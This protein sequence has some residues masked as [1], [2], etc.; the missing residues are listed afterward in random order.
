MKG[1]D[2]FILVYFVLM[3]L[4]FCGANLLMSGSEKKLEKNYLIEISRMIHEH[5]ETGEFH[6]EN[7]ESILDIIP[8]TDENWY[9]TDSNYAVRE[10]GGK[11]YRIDYI[12]YESDGNSRKIMNAVIIAVS[13]SGLI[14]LIWIRRTV[15]KPFNTIYTLPYSLAKGNLTVP[16]QENKN[17]YFGKFLWGLDM[18][19][20]KLE[21]SKQQKLEQAKAEKLMLLSLSHDIKTP[22]SAIR[23]Y[24]KALSSGLYS[25]REKQIAAADSIQEKTTEIEKY[26]EKIMSNARKDFLQF[27]VNIQEFYLSSVMERINAYYGEKFGNLHTEFICEKYGDCMLSGDSER[28]EEVLQN[29]L[30]N[31]VKYGDGGAVEISFADEEDCRLITVK[32]TGCTL[33]DTELP[34]IFESFW[35]GSNADEKQGSGL[36]LYICRKLM[37]AMGGEVFAEIQNGCMYVSVV[38]RRA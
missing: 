1:F 36:G 7:Y 32:N 3:I 21:E 8:C 30:E 24:A 16:L 34:H 13:L 2:R 35:R 28:L 6:T 17:R 4:L 12:S 15:L 37:N 29:I 19:R 25:E 11:L 27:D 31:A 26:V 5:E 14:I 10:I 38:C 20:E 33:S 23:L 22:L 18:L 9:L